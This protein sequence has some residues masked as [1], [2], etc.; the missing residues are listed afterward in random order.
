MVPNEISFVGLL[1][2]CSHAGM[3]KEG[4]GFLSEMESKYG[5]SPSIEHT[6]V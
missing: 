3:V 5:V 2:A 4:L 6:P 1:S